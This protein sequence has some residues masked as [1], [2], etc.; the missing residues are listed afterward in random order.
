MRP[1]IQDPDGSVAAWAKSFAAD[2]RGRTTDVLG[3]MLDVFR[4]TFSYNAREAEGTQSP[5]KPCA[6]SRV[7]AGTMRG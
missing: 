7:L 6:R 5:V 3:R 4:D 2:N 1:H